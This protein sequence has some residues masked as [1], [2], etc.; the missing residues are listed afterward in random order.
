MKTDKT[1][2]IAELTGDDWGSTPSAASFRLRERYEIRR[3]QLV[4]LSI[5]EIKLL[6]EIDYQNDS[7]YLV[8]H[9]LNKIGNSHSNKNYEALSLLVL[10][11]ANKSF[12][13]SGS[14]EEIAKS[15]AASKNWMNVLDDELSVAE[16]TSDKLEFYK[17]SYVILAHQ[18]MLLEKLVEWERNAV[19]K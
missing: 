16:S 6:L 9:G 3:K 11:L 19:N 5:P 7:N 15:R 13:W 1:K 12:N 17:K 2:S 4:E 14:K 10:I 18:N 8:P